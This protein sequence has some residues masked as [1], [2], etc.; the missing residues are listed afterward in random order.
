M[1]YEINIYIYILRHKIKTI[2]GAAKLW[3]SLLYYRKQAR[4]ACASMQ[5]RKKCMAS[6]FPLMTFPNSTIFK[7]IFSQFHIFQLYL[8]PIPPFVTSSFSNSTFSNLI[9]SQFQ[10]F[11]LYLFT[12]VPIPTS[13]FP[14]STFFQFHLFSR[15]ICSVHHSTLKAPC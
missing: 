9:F 3:N 2:V 7:S 5:P 13:S 10:L 6:Q 8:F 4:F 12:I 11:K 15:F 14:N 1:A